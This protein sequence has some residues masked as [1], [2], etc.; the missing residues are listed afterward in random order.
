[1]STV[2]GLGASLGLFALL[3]VTTVSA[4]ACSPSGT[5]GFDGILVRLRPSVVET[6][7][8]RADLSI[9]AADPA[10]QSVAK[11]TTFA[12]GPF[13]VLGVAFPAGTRDANG[14]LRGA[15]QS[16]TRGEYASATCV[17]GGHHFDVRCRRRQRSPWS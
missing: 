5:A 10:G 13:D 15:N 6:G 4:P 9:T 17:L 8:A 7:T 11:M 14:R 2:P 1:M 3:A 16:S 12:S